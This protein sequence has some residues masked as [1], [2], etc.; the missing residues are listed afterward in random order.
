MIVLKL[1]I[2]FLSSILQAFIV[3]EIFNAFGDKRFDNKWIV[4]GCVVLYAILNSVLCTFVQIQVVFVLGGL[5]L[6][7]VFS[8][9]Y[10]VYLWKRLFLVILTG[11][12][13][14]ASEMLSGLIMS[15][16][17]SMNVAD[18]QDNIGLYIQGMASSKLI[19]LGL[20]K[21]LAHRRNKKD[22]K[23][24]WQTVVMLI[25][26]PISSFIVLAVLSYFIFGLNDTSSIVLVTI[27]SALL[28]LSNLIV[29]FVFDYL[30]KQKAKEMEISMHSLQLEMEKQYY[31]DLTQKYIMSNKTF[32]DLK[33]KLYAIETLM[34]ENFDLAKDEIKSAC[35]IVESA[36]NMKYTGNDAVDSLLNSK[37]TVA[38]DKGID[39][40][41]T[42]M[43]AN[44]SRFK[45][46]DICVI[47]GNI[48]DNAISATCQSDDYRTIIME[49]KQIQERI[50]ITM[51]NP[52]NENK[53]LKKDKYL[54]G[55]GLKSVHEIVEKYD[56]DCRYGTQEE[57][58][59]INILL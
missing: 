23:L 40:K 56:G 46:I 25:A 37:I 50:S 57:K 43:V 12:L 27:A 47:L 33:H 30:E 42:S 3:V 48:F 5:I 13:I 49:I 21:A 52:I 8:L 7:A 9:L 17:Y 6:I 53:K 31:F 58:F 2:N 32:H 1:L 20:C 26:L 36:Q 22:V 19:L 51:T 4:R 10:K 18:V 41:I 45:I 44:F 39:V 35:H 38:K 54:H 34:N 14:I 59:I 16:I 24:Y 28:L 29:I 15:A 55:Y 11:V